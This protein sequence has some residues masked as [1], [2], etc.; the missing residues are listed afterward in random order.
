MRC[1]SGDCAGSPSYSRGVSTTR[2][3]GF[4]SAADVLIRGSVLYPTSGPHFLEI[5]FTN[6]LLFR[7][8]ALR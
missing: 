5:K 1:E 7:P 4:A 8:R 2:G 3:P 6:N